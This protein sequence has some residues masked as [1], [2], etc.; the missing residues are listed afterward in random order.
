MT[1]RCGDRGFLLCRSG[2]PT[3]LISR[4]FL[5]L[6]KRIILAIIFR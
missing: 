3:H 6:C 5:F 4:V 2:F 1:D